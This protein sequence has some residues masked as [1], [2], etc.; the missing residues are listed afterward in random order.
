MK[1]LIQ[2]LAM[3][4]V[5]VVYSPIIAGS[6][7][8]APTLAGM[9]YLLWTSILATVVLLLLLTVAYRVELK[10][11]SDEEGKHD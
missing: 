1:R 11:L 5:L 6:D 10:R 3:L 9:P 8:A 4:L 2:L 7:S